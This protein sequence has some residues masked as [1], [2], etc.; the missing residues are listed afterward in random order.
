M[1]WLFYIEHFYSSV[2]N[3]WKEDLSLDVYTR[4][5]V[6]IYIQIYIYL[7]S[8]NDILDLFVSFFP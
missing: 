6:H 1:F 4:V 8:D 7:Q 2:H 3:N 5:C